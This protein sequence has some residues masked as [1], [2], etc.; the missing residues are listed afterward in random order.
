[1]YINATEEGKRLR[2]VDLA[3]QHLTKAKIADGLRAF[4]HGGV[5]SGIWGGIGTYSRSIPIPFPRPTG[6]EPE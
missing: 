3:P 2:A 6:I 1:M 4:F 5:N